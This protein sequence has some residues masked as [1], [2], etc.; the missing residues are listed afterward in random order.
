MACLRFF[1]PRNEVTLA[2]P[3]STPQGGARGGRRLE[4]APV[5]E[6]LACDRNV[7]RAP[8]RRGLLWQHRQQ[9]APRFHRR[10]TGGQRGEPHRRHV[11]VGG[12]ADPRSRRRSRNPAPGTRARSLPSD[13]S[14]CAG[15]ASRRNC[16][17]S[18]VWFELAPIQPGIGVFRLRPSG[19]PDTTRRN[20]FRLFPASLRSS[21][22]KSRSATCGP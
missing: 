3:R 2:R 20:D 6:G 14:L 7:S 21:A 18:I 4:R 5:R 12:S 16:S 15:S 19:P 17:R 8:F 22:W 10:R 13:A 9:G 11:P 1:L